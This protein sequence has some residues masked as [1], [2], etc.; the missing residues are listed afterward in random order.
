MDFSI[1]NVDRTT[2]SWPSEEKSGRTKSKFKCWR[3]NPKSQNC[4]IY[5]VHV[6]KI[7]NLETHQTTKKNLKFLGS[8]A[9]SEALNN[10]ACKLHGCFCGSVVSNTVWAHNFSNKTKGHVYKARP[11]AIEVM[12]FGQFLAKIMGKKTRFG[13]FQLK[14]N[15]KSGSCHPNLTRRI[16]LRHPGPDFF[17]VLK[18]IRPTSV[19][20]VIFRPQVRSFFGCKTGNCFGENV[21][22]LLFFTGSCF[23]ENV[24][25]LLFLIGNC[26]G[27]NSTETRVAF[28]EVALFY[29]GSP[30][31]FFPEI[32]ISGFFGHAHLWKSAHFLI[33]VHFP[34]DGGG[35]DGGVPRTLPIW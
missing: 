26:F 17:D 16:D 25:E 18:K 11:K 30:A 20:K 9:W 29:V 4:H 15:W 3:K 34:D 33:F 13:D 1:E 32:S 22:G 27:E 21:L 2:Q 19:S 31:F 8:A 10:L 23:G 7:Q 24:L 5:T 35:D 14:W 28:F 12:D 6:S